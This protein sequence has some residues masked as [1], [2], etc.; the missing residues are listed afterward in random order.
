MMSAFQFLLS[1]GNFVILTL[2]LQMTLLTA[3]ALILAARF[4][5]SA[6]TRYGILY[7]A[8][9][10]VAVLVVASLAMQFKDTALFTFEVPVESRQEFSTTTSGFIFDEFELAEIDLAVA[11][12]TAGL[13]VQP[14]LKTLSP[15]R[16]KTLLAPGNYFS[17]CRLI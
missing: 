6:A 17:A 15:Y 5:N 14:L 2:L 7:P 9:I 10:S 11:D 4:K 12:P 1:D 3:L 16:V 13:P 8:L